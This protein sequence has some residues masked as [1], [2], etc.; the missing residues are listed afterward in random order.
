MIDLFS[1]MTGQNILQSFTAKNFSYLNDRHQSIRDKLKK[2]IEKDGRAEVV[3]KIVKQ[4]ST[5][6]VPQS[7]I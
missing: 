4:L 2:N 3:K 5:L 6:L 1:E 7:E